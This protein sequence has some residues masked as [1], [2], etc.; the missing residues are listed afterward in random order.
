MSAHLAPR[1]V[2]IS[3]LVPRGS[4]PLALTLRGVYH[5]GATGA[6]QA[7]TLAQAL[8]ADTGHPYPHTV[9]PDV[10]AA[11]VRSYEQRESYRRAPGEDVERYLCRVRAARGGDR[12]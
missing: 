7:F 10:I 4:G 2:E 5:P 6:E 9:Y 12:G 8:R 3:A 11:A 1:A